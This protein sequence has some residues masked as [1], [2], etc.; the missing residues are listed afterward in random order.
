MVV[1][2][3][4]QASYVNLTNIQIAILLIIVFGM[5]ILDEIVYRFWFKVFCRYLQYFACL[6]H[7]LLWV[8]TSIYHI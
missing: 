1:F 7:L 8:A 3:F 6:N 4:S 5:K 2:N